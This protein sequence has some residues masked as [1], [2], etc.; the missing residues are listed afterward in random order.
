MKKLLLLFFAITLTGLGAAFDH[1]HSDF[2][3]VLK[4]RVKNEEV[5][6][7]ELKASPGKLGAYLVALSEVTEKE[8]E[9]WNDDRQKAFLINLY[10]AATL[11]LVI[12]HYPVKSIKD[13]RSPWKQKRVK[14]FGRAVSLDH[15]EHEMLRKNYDD[16]RIHF[17]VNCASGGCPALR[18]EAFQA[19]KLDSQLDEQARK[20]LADGNKNR[21]DSG[22]GI[23]YL[24][25]IFD[26]FEGDFVGKSGSVEKFIAPFLSSAG[27]KSVE[28]GSL[29]IKY[30][31]YDWSLNGR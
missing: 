22:K 5:D 26:W 1:T 25:P 7:H 6:Y 15:V 19:A 2:T 30:T 17:G 8:F 10:N 3:A 4:K 29:K 28:A 13:I 12:D 27:R 24:S 21:I 11:K 14:I 20:F 16:P 31:D 23:L 9:S 18:G